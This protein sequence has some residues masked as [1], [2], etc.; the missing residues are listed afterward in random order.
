MGTVRLQC[1]TNSSCHTGS[2]AW[3]RTGRNSQ[4]WPRRRTRAGASAHAVVVGVKGVERSTRVRGQNISVSGTGCDLHHRSDTQQHA[5][6]RTRRLRRRDK[7]GAPTQ[8][9]RA[10]R[11]GAESTQSH[12]PPPALKPCARSFRSAPRCAPFV[13]RHRRLPSTVPELRGGYVASARRVH[14]STYAGFNVTIAMGQRVTT[15]ERPSGRSRPRWAATPPVGA[16]CRVS[17]ESFCRR[18][19]E[20]SPSSELGRRKR[21]SRTADAGAG[22]DAQQPKDL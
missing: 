9:G 14:H 3:G 11:Q 19:V 16:E 20:G 21:R 1:R 12:D 17:E 18:S 13:F 5:D 7:T 22:P 6:I 10:Q 8:E 15:R 2:A 4:R